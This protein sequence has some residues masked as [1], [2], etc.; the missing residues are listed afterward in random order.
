MLDEEDNTLRRRRS[1][2]YLNDKDFENPDNIDTVDQLIETDP[3][4]LNLFGI[5]EEDLDLWT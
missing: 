3:D 1:S 2:L 5:I 4:F